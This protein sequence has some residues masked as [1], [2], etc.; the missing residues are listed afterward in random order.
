MLCVLIMMKTLN[1][2]IEC[3]DLRYD[4]VAFSYFRL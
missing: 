2:V 3:Q 4:F 1:F